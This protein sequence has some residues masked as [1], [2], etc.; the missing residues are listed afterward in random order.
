[1]ANDGNFSSMLEA[2]HQNG[3]EWDGA[4]ATQMMSGIGH[5]GFL[6]MEYRAHGDDWMELALPWRDDLAGDAE[7]DVLAS[8]PIIALMDNATALSVWV[9]LKQ[10]RPQVTL[11]LRVD[12][13][14]AATPGKTVIGRGECIKITRSIAFVRGV[15]HDGDPAD[16]VALVAGSFIKLDGWA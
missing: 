3:W 2:A 11:D 1:M 14:R 6:G 4:M 10:F 8:G 5:S 15:A 13:M 9:K 12:Y 16:P 7:S